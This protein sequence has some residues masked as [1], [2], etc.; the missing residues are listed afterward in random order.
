M[1][2]SPWFHHPPGPWAWN[3]IIIFISL[4]PPSQSFTN[5][6]DPFSEMAF[7]CFSIHIKHLS[8]DFSLLHTCITERI[9]FLVSVLSF[10]LMITLKITLLASIISTCFFGPRSQNNLMCI[11]IKP[12]S[13]ESLE[14]VYYLCHYIIWCAPNW[15]QQ[16]QLLSVSINT[17]PVL[18]YACCLE[19]NCLII[20]S[21]KCPSSIQILIFFSRTTLFYPTL[22]IP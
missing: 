2:L 20:T 1:Y 13:K 18:S 15:S 7:R 17:H 14:A 9:I 8:I 11:K 12:N 22:I 5:P 10:L 3:L 4:V 16:D 6:A 19:A 21:F